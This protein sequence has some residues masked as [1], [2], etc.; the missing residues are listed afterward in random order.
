MGYSPGDFNTQDGKSFHWELKDG[1]RIVLW[2]HNEL[3]Q[4]LDLDLENAKAA[5]KQLETCIM[6]CDPDFP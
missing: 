6:L 2:N 4:P 1:H 3:E 5:Y